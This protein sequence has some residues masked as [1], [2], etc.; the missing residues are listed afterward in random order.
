MIKYAHV[1]MVCGFLQAG[2]VGFRQVGHLDFDCILSNSMHQYSHALVVGF[3]FWAAYC[4]CR[5]SFISVADRSVGS[6]TVGRQMTHHPPGLFSSSG[7][8]LLLS[9]FL[10]PQQPFSQQV[11]ASIASLLCLRKF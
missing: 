3:A 11:S 5:E 6:S 4:A 10:V 1:N 9:K 7:D 8:D 2:Q